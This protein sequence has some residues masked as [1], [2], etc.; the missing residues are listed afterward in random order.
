[1]KRSGLTFYMT[2][3]CAQN[4]DIVSLKT[5]DIPKGRAFVTAKED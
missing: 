5:E 2:L 3:H 1:V 4:T